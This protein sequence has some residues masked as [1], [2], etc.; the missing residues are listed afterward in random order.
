MVTSD[1]VSVAASLEGKEEVR[2][3][4][5]QP[6]MKKKHETKKAKGKKRKKSAVSSKSTW[7]FRGKSIFGRRTKNNSSKKINNNKKNKQKEKKKKKKKH[8]KKTKKMMQCIHSSIKYLRP[9]LTD[10][11]HGSL[12]IY[13]VDGQHP[14]LND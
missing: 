11:I 10:R 7:K 13:S 3:T 8:E 2:K 5:A 6:K 4:R 12:A 14:S 9:D 1:E